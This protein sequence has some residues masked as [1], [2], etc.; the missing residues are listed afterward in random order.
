MAIILQAYHTLILR[1]YREDFGMEFAHLNKQV[2]QSVPSNTLLEAIVDEAT[3]IAF[4]TYLLEHAN[5]PLQKTYI[6]HA[7]KDERKHL[8]LFSQIYQKQTGHAPNYKIQPVPETSLRDGFLQALNS[9]LGAQEFYR[10][11]YF[12]SSQPDVRS[13]F[14]LAMLD[15]IEHAI[16]FSTLLSLSS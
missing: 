8:A 6:E 10:K 4:Y 9:E 16:R 2:Q 14:Y 7:L 12:S 3:A 11:I 1:N 13:G 15:E 5:T